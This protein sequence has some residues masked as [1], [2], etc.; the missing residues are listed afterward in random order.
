MAHDKPNYELIYGDGS[1]DQLTLGE[2][3]LSCN[4]YYKLFEI[5]I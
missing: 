1:E 3:S 5:R 4:L 2:K